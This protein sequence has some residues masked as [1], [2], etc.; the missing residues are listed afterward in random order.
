M[1]PRENPRSV[2]H[3][4]TIQPAM[5]TKAF[6][7]L[8]LEIPPSTFRIRFS[9]EEAACRAVARQR[10]VSFPLTRLDLCTRKSSQHLPREIPSQSRLDVALT[11]RGLQILLAL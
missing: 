7:V 2:F 9:V 8:S 10:R 4:R 5:G 1:R 11:P 3:A 6:P